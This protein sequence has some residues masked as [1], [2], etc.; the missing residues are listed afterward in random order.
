MLKRVLHFWGSFL[1]SSD[2]A[3]VLGTDTYGCVGPT[4]IKEMSTFTNDAFESHLPFEE[5]SVCDAK[6]HGYNAWDHLF[7]RE[8]RFDKGVTARHCTRPPENHS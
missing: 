5:I 4:G 7:T 2:P 8:F 3:H 6:D 1:T